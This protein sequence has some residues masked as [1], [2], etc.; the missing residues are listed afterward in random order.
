MTAIIDPTAFRLAVG[1]E[2]YRPLLI[3]ARACGA[4]E[5][6]TRVLVEDLLADVFGYDKYT[7]MS[8]EYLE[9]G[10]CCDLALQLG[11]TAAMLIEVRAAGTRVGDA[12]R[13]RAIDH[14]VAQGCPWVALTNGAQWQVY[15]I[16]FAEPLKVEPVVEFDLLELDPNLPADLEKALLLTREGWYEGRLPGYDLAHR[17]RTRHA[18]AAALLTDPVL[19]AIQRQ[20]SRAA[21]HADIN[22]DEI[23]LMLCV[24]VLNPEPLLGPD[25]E[26]ARRLLGCTWFPRAGV[27]GT[28]LTRPDAPAP[29]DYA[30][31]ESP[32][33]ICS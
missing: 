13:E 27:M 7:Q 32:G 19:R 16:E 23:A 25:A 33:E 3:A 14:A 6:A 12:Q 4:D 2:R 24:D 8:A 15:R 20:L 11:G 22:I 28:P 1:L 17:V 26:D 9:R 18:L 5:A 10:A 29:S 21:P 31:R 30:L